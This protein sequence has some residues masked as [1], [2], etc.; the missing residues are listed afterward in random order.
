MYIDESDILEPPEEGWPHMENL[1]WMGKTDEVYELLRHLPY[2]RNKHPEAEDRTT[3]VVAPLCHFISWSEIAPKATPGSGWG[4]PDEDW[5][6]SLRLASEPYELV[7][8]DSI[9]PSI[10]GLTYN[11]WRDGEYY[12][13]DTARGIVYWYECYGEIRHRP[14]HAPPPSDIDDP[15]EWAPENE[16]EWRGDHPAWALADL[17][18]IL[19]QQFE[20]LNFVP[21]GP[22]NVQE[23]FTMRDDNRAVISAVQGIYR[24]H[25]WPDLATYRKEDCLR[26][27]RRAMREE[28]PE[29]IEFRQKEDYQ[30]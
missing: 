29:F 23:V 27:V 10:V 5:G 30:D 13:L 19:R 12:L 24:Q 15:Y 7:D 21:L 28:F 9:P 11:R 2:L 20:D 14:D 8:E 22:R 4:R 26:A 17:F 1:R 6:R 3:P 18:A 25:G 16:R